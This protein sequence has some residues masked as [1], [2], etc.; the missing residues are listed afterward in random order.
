MRYCLLHISEETG[1]ETGNFNMMISAS[2]W[3][4]FTECLFLL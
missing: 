2:T 4:E 1:I 3:T